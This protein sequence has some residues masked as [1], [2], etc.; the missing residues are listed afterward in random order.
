M[1]DYP[2]LPFVLH[3]SGPLLE[4]LVENQHGYI[5]RMKALVDSGRVE[6]LGGGFFEPILTM[7]PHRDRV[8]QIRAFA[9]YLEE[10]FGVRPRGVWIAE[11]VWEQHLVS[12][13]AEAGVEYTVLDDFHFQRAGVDDREMKGFF[14][15]EEDGHLLKVFPISERLRY[16]IPF[17]EPHDCYEHLRRVAAERPRLGG[18]L[19]R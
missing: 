3:T 18:C 13:L 15:T 16:L 12:A 14:L 5:A 11:R 7:I 9:D 6:I 1:E 19:R 8:G 10:V 17:R 2:D 4:W